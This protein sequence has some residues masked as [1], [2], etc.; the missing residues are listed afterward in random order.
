MQ[1][2]MYEVLKGKTVR[3]EYE[4]SVLAQFTVFMP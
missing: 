3:R 2:T 1:H 4:L